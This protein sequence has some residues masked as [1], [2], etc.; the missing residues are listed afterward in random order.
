MILD[1]WGISPDPDVSAIEQADTPFVDSLYKNYPH[2][3]LL[4][5]GMNVGLPEG[6]MLRRAT[7]IEQNKRDGSVPVNQQAETLAARALAGCHAMPLEGK[8]KFVRGIWFCAPNDPVET[9]ASDIAARALGGDVIQGACGS[10]A[11]ARNH[12]DKINQDV[13]LI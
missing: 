6:Q 7:G 5:D 4:T 12:A 10:E 2:A 8:L 3:T 9:L 11:E 1:G 13:V